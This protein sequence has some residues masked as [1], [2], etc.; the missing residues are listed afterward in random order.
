MYSQKWGRAVSFLRI[1]VSNFRYSVFAVHISDSCSSLHVCQFSE[2]NTSTFLRIRKCCRFFLWAK[3]RRRFCSLHT[4]VHCTVYTAMIFPEIMR[5]RHGCTAVYRHLWLKPKISLFIFAKMRN[6]VFQIFSCEI[7]LK[8]DNFLF[9]GK[10]IRFS[11]ASDFAH[12][13]RFF[14]EKNLFKPDA[15]VDLPSFYLSD[16]QRSRP[17]LLC[18]IVAMQL[19]VEFL[20]NFYKIREISA[21]SVNLYVCEIYTKIFIL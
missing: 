10:F 7:C 17:C 11:I 21:F 4:N 8:K 3:S 5:N 13:N 2:P 6:F 19:L 14:A 15:P 12:S 18:T 20:K 16:L 1:F 9:C